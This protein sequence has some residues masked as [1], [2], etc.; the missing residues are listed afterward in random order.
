[1]ENSIESVSN[2][3]EKWISSMDI[4]KKFKKQNKNIN[5]VIS[6]YWTVAQIYLLT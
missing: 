4:A 2:N 1:M 5:F 3:G 6:S